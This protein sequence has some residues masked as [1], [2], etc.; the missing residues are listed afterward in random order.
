MGGQVSVYGSESGGVVLA[1]G[2]DGNPFTVGGASRILESSDAWARNDFDGEGIPGFNGTLDPATEV[3]NT[4]A[5]PNH[6][7][8]RN[9][10]GAAPLERNLPSSSASISMSRRIF[11]SRARTSTR[12]LRTGSP[13]EVTRKPRRV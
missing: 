4:P 10:G 6:R 9:G 1:P 8:Y 5:D 11:R 12:G 7:N 3:L 2:F 13:A